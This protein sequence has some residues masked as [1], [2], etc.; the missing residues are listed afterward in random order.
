MHSHEYKEPAQ[1]TGKRV[2]LLGAAPSGE[3]LALELSQGCDDLY[4][5]ARKH[6][7]LEGRNPYGAKNNIH[8]VLGEISRI[9]ANKV[10]IAVNGEET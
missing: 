6:R 10:H 2:L 3:D 7:S 5:V 8:K 4:L 9:D 1:V